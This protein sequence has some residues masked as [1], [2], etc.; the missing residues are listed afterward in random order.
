MKMGIR[1]RRRSPA[2]RRARVRRVDTGRSW[3]SVAVERCRYQRHGADTIVPETG[4]GVDAGRLSPTS[5][6]PQGARPQP[7]DH[8][9]RKA[10]VVGAVGFEP[11]SSCSQSTCATVAPRPDR[12]RAREAHVLRAQAAATEPTPLATAGGRVANRW[13]RPPPLAAD[14]N[15]AQRQASLQAVREAAPLGRSPDRRGQRRATGETDPQRAYGRRRSASAGR[16]GSRPGVRSLM[17][18]Q[19]RLKCPPLGTVQTHGGAR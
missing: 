15:A 2:R 9:A 18:P 8:R 11:T 5:S 19:V 1:A 13:L 6:S 14:G 16:G 17:R 3:F 7:R 10:M 4:R 12:F